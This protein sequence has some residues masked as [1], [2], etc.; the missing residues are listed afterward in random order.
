V[1]YQTTNHPSTQ[2]HYVSVRSGTPGLPRRLDEN[3]YLYEMEAALPMA[4][5]ECEHGRLAG[6]RTPEC[7]CWPQEAHVDLERAYRRGVRTPEA[8]EAW[9]SAERL[10]YA[11]RAGRPLRSRK[12]CS[13]CGVAV[14]NRTKGCRPCGQRHWQ[15]A[16]RI[17]R[18]V[19]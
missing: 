13:G 10:R 18:A 8:R 17:A 7:G 1:T 11:R 15:R 14:D 9:A 12:F 16:D 19:L 5:F 3:P 4:D 2:M 6:D